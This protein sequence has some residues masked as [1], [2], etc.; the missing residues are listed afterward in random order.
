MVCVCGEV[1]GFGEISIFWEA[2]QA[3]RRA[4]EAKKHIEEEQEPNEL[5]DALEI[6]CD[7]V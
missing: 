5:C 1:D 4:D 7:E 2:M 6:G 3:K